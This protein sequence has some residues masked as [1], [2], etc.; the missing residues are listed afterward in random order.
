MASAQ[1]RHRLM[2][3]YLPLFLDVARRIARRERND[4]GA[5]ARRLL[6]KGL[7]ADFLLWLE[8]FY[9]EHAGFAADQSRPLYRSYAESVAPVAGEEVGGETVLTPEAD[10]FV[11]E[12]IEMFGQRYADVSRVR[13]RQIVEGALDEGRDPLEAL[14]AALDGW[15]ER[16]GAEVAR[17]ESSRF[18]NAIS[19]A[20]YGLI[21]REL[22][23]W[24]AFGESCPY[25]NA[26][27]GR[28]IGIRE[29]YLSAGQDFQPDGA[30]VPLRP[31]GNIRHP[32]AHDGCD[33][34]VVAG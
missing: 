31:S 20:I 23:R 24:L 2:M 8:D 29:F 4:V 27:N 21:G 33:C 18:N 12:Y 6:P 22:L 3:A 5:A 16:R 30:E 14:E 7:V 19:V 28:V 32:P 13:M 9:R 15:E 1:H 26:L 10:A 17:W 11:D 34:M 25:C